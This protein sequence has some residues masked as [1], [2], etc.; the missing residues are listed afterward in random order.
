MRNCHSLSRPNSPG[1]DQNGV[2]FNTLRWDVVCV[3][4]T[5]FSF[6]AGRLVRWSRSSANGS[7]RA[8][9]EDYSSK[10]SEDGSN[11]TVFGKICQVICVFSCSL[12]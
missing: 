1:Q 6:A 8:I 2:V 3:L 10:S 4:C 12:L 7:H 11:G 5:G 9:G